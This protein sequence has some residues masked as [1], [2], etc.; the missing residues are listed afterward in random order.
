MTN[1][2]FGVTALLMQGRRSRC[3]KGQGGHW[4]SWPSEVWAIIEDNTFL[5]MSWSPPNFWTFRRSSDE[6]ESSPS[7]QTKQFF[8]GLHQQSIT[9]CYLYQHLGVYVLCSKINI[10]KALKKDNSCRAK[11]IFI[12]ACFSFL[13]TRYFCKLAIEKKLV[14]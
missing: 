3:D 6:E 2:Y 14:L 12:I 9:A 7:C 4:S 8:N 13:S 1:D 10:S 11:L 5:L